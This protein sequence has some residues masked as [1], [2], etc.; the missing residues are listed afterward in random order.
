MIIELR[1]K[2]EAMS[3]KKK[4]KK[5]QIDEDKNLPCGWLGR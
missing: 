1:K 2:E 5:N 4:R 3:L